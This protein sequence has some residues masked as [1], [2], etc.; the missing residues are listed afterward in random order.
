MQAGQAL[1]E[2]DDRLMQIAAVNIELALLSRHGRHHARV[3][4]T[5]AGDVIVHVDIPSAVCA[6]EV[7]ALAPHDMQR[8]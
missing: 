1:G 8:L 2:G 6:E 4:V 5:D 7:D 3:G